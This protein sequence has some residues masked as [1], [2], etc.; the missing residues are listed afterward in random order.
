[1]DLS[2][3]LCQVSIRAA[4][5]GCN[6]WLCLREACNHHSYHHHIACSTVAASL[7]MFVPMLIT[8]KFKERPNILMYQKY[9]KKQK[10]EN[11]Q[12]SCM[13]SLVAHSQTAHGF[14]TEMAA[15][16]SA[17]KFWER[18]LM[19]ALACTAECQLQPPVEAAVATSSSV[20]LKVL[21]ACYS[22]A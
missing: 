2:S 13:Q 8:I 14:L 10:K 9:L 4:H 11:K 19:A 18:Q 7:G 5:H 15:R 22:A 12:Q 1:M 17:C 21:C 16:N 20:H 6:G 3:I